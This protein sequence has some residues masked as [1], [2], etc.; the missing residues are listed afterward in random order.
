LIK[1]VHVITRLILGGAQENTLLTVEGLVRDGRFDVTL[2]TGP[3]LGPEGQ[4]LERAYASGA[5]VI[6]IPEMRREIHP[7]RDLSTAVS[8]D[9]VLRRL[10]PHIVHTHSSKA[11]IIGRLVA[12]WL[13]VPVVVHT[14]HGM[15]FH[16]YERWYLNALYRNLERVA[17]L[18]S[19]KIITVANAMTA[20]AL[21]AEIAPAEKFRTIYSGM[22]VECFL[23]DP[24]DRRRLREIYGIGPD[25]IVVGKVARLAELK[26][27]EYL[28][29]AAEELALR[30]GDLKFLLVGD[31]RLRDEIER[32][33]NARG[34]TDRFIFAG[35][36]A[37]D[38]IPGMIRMMDIVVHCSLREGLARVLPQGLVSAKP[39][40][41]FD[42]DG[43]PEVVIDGK[44]GFLV[45]PG[46]V[47]MLVERL[48]AL[49]ESPALRQKLGE[50]GR[51]CFAEQFRWQHMVKEI[52]GEYDVLLRQAA[53]RRRPVS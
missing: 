16:P 33:V 26:G 42:V 10:R 31:G 6:V 4:L 38:R 35:L 30:F 36:V 23:A 14:I 7:I 50:A 1:V 27:H 46:N 37:P 49:I 20:A 11:G 28:V 9:R 40:V 52:I 34:L 29:Q 13:R 3:P 24:G 51:E 5:R 45:R 22:E 18:A 39:V 47:P 19:D 41:S 2:V 21:D 12:R 44:T 48:A 15:P 8:L 32:D 17:G 53:R 43:A 25:T